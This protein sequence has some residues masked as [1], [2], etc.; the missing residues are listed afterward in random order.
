MPATTNAIGGGM[1]TLRDTADTAVVPITNA[2]TSPTVLLPARPAAGRTTSRIRLLNVCRPVH[3]LHVRIAVAL[4]DAEGIQG[5]SMRQVA[6]C[7]GRP[8]AR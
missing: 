4:A 8:L 1:P 2:S 7:W 3:G 5:V 6:T